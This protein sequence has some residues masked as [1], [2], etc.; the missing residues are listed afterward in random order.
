MSCSDFSFDFAFDGVGTDGELTF[1]PTFNDYLGQTYYPGTYVVTIS[2]TPVEE[3]SPT[4]LT[5]T[6][7]I[8]LVDPCASVSITFDAAADQTYVLGDPE[9]TYQVGVTVTPADCPVTYTANIGSLPGNQTP[10]S[11]DE[12]NS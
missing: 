1:A 4:T 11:F 6:F 2:G 8:V 3:D 9:Q 7:N 5:E 10:T 12:P